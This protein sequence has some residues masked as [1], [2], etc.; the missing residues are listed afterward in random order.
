MKK[1]LKF[2]FWGFLVLSSALIGYSLA[3]AY[4]YT[5]LNNMSLMTYTDA[6]NIDPTNVAGNVVDSSS[7]TISTPPDFGPTRTFGMVSG[8]RDGDSNTIFQDGTGVKFISWHTPNPIKLTGVNLFA[9]CDVYNNTNQGRAITNF[10][11]SYSL[12]QGSTWIPIVNNF[13]TDVSQYDR[14]AYTVY[15]SVSWWGMAANFA[16]DPVT[17]SYFKA[18]FTQ[19]S[20]PGG[21]TP[22]ARVCELD[23]ITSAVPIPGAVWLLGSGLAG[24]GLM[25]F[26]KK[27]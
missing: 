3:Q 10:S 11:L 9:Y 7:L 14:G 5:D 25:R 26:R 4:V 24:L 23:A 22:G 19:W 27:A 15:T 18:E 20:L 17:A 12:N 21:A 1:F 13:A 6:W 2:A 16:F 8:G